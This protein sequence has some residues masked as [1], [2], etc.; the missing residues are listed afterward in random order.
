MLEAVLMFLKRRVKTNKSLM[1]PE[2]PL[3]PFSQK[4]NE[5]VVSALYGSGHPGCPE[6]SPAYCSTRASLPAIRR[7]LDG[8]TRAADPRTIETFRSF[9][10]RVPTSQGQHRRSVRGHYDT[11]VRT[12]DTC[13]GSS[14][15][16]EPSGGP[17]RVRRGGSHLSRPAQDA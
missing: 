13:T 16:R 8:P 9:R 12:Q 6:P 14:A 3:T 1:L 7:S 15:R 11:R 17:P 4:S 5:Q 10:W 2:N